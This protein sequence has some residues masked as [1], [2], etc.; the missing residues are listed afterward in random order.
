MR[1]TIL[2]EKGFHVREGDAQVFYN[3]VDEPLP[4]LRDVKANLETSCL[5]ILSLSTLHYSKIFLI[6]AK[7]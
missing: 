2:Q 4:D 6:L 5:D 1:L 7:R 3:V